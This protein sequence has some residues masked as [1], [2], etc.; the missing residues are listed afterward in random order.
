MSLDRNLGAH[1]Q[2]IDLLPMQSVTGDGNGTGVDL[3]QFVGSV[4]VMLAAKNTA[5]TTP[6]LDIKLQDSADNST[7]WA[8]ITGAVFTQVT[9]ANTS[10]ATLEKIVL[11]VDACAR[12]VRAVKDIGG[13][14]SPAFDVTCV[15]VGVRQVR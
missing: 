14:S 13:T 5:G 6:T 3:Q 4:A 9:D 1:L 11:N 2:T 15:G 10:A 12:Y 7:G 8:D